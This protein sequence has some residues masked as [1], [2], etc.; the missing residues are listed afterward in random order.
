[1]SMPQEPAI[2]SYFFGKGYRDLWDTIKDSWQRNLKSA[3]NLSSKADGA[4]SF[5]LVWWY[6]AAVSVVVFGTAVFLIASVAHIVVLA[7]FF[8]L[9]YLAFSFVYLAERIFLAIRGFS[10]VCP[11]CHSRNPLP[12]YFCS[13]CGE[14]HQRLIPSSYGILRRI[15]QCG[16]RLPSTFFLKRGELS[17]KCPDCGVLLSREHTETKK[18][19]IPIVGGPAVGKSSYLLSAVRGLVEEV[20]PSLGVEASF[21]KDM[22]AEDF[23]HLCEG[24]DKGRPPEKT[25][26][27]LPR[28]FNLKL[29]G[30][31]TPRLIYLYDPAGEAYAATGEML[32][33]KYQEYFS[34]MI[35][36]IDPFALPM[37]R[38]EFEDRIETCLGALKP[39]DLSVE[40]TLSRLLISLEESFGLS[41]TG[42]IRAP[43][44]VV[45]NKVDAFDLEGQITRAVPTGEITQD[46]QA[47]NQQNQAIQEWLWKWD[48]GGLVHQIETRF[49]TV[50]YFVCSALGH[51]P[52]PSAGAFA[53]QGVLE[54]LLWILNQADGSFF[55]Q[56]G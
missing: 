40:D 16:Q 24:L 18:L 26:D 35:F 45:V 32:L 42:R 46:T 29:T 43:L 4:D 56:R 33:H 31:L 7:I 23:Q 34:G 27:R 21:L 12:H 54:P 49:S 17:S 15:C 36:L 37:V 30:G 55:K 47:W 41:K 25:Q 44:A 8:T 9:I 51:M 14:V 1:M 5:P 3:G 50:R 6:S 39:S 53:P 11:E 19:F 20:A 38:Q 2:K 28:A 22:E 10:A 52:D 48:A 13:S